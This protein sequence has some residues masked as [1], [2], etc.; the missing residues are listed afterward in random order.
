MTDETHSRLTLSLRAV[1]AAWA[2]CGLVALGALFLTTIGS[3][4]PPSA[5]PYAGARIPSAT[6]GDPPSAWAE[7]DRDDVAGEDGAGTASRAESLV[8]SPHDGSALSR[9]RVVSSLPMRTGSLC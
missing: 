1:L 2:C 7:D 9:H 8:C 6:G 3:N 5:S 4:E